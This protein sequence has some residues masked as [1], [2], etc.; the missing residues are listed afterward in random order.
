MPF[1]LLLTE[2]LHAITGR[3]LFDSA[4]RRARSDHAEFFIGA[5]FLR[6]DR[7]E[8][9]VDSFKRSQAMIHNEGRRYFSDLDEGG[10]DCPLLIAASAQ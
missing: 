2:P 9:G 6:R 10:F 5:S 4:G 8:R 1:S 7:P 3:S